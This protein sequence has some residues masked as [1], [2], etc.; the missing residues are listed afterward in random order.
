M[1]VAE[2]WAHAQRATAFTL[3]G[4]GEA[5]RAVLGLVESHVGPHVAHGLGMPAVGNNEIMASSA[6]EIGLPDITELV[7][8]LCLS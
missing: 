8:A 4:E 7:K 6:R 2:Q 3:W 1:A 5:L